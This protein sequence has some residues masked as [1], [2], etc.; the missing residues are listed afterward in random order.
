MNQEYITTKEAAKILGISRVHVVRKIKKGDISAVKVGYS[1]IIPKES[2]F[3]AISKSLNKEEQ[4]RVSM[5]VEK[6][7]T[8]YGGVL[9]KLGKE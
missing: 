8:A 5:A 6:T 3:S 4:D 1:Y 2:L 7:I 9:Q